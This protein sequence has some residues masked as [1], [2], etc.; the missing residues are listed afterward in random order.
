MRGENKKNVVLT[1]L[2]MILIFF[3]SNF[4]IYISKGGFKMKKL[5]REYY[6]FCQER[7][8]LEKCLENISEE[9]GY[10]QDSIYAYDFFEQNEIEQKIQELKNL[11]FELN[12]QLDQVYNVLEIISTEK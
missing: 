11:K 7:E 10:L 3:K 2:N 6:Y 12:A 5:E 4:D 8:R 1:F 9:I